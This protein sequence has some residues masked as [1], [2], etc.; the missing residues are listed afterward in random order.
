MDSLLLWS[1]QLLASHLFD[2][3]RNSSKSGFLELIT[4]S[5]TLLYIFITV[6]HIQLYLLFSNCI[7]LYLYLDLMGYDSEKVEEYET[8][9]DPAK[10][11][12]C[13]WG[14]STNA[15]IESLI[16]L[17]LQLERVDIIS[18]MQQA[19]PHLASSNT[20]CQ[21]TSE[22][23]PPA[24]LQPINNITIYEREYDGRENE[25][26]PHVVPVENITVA[27]RGV[28]NVGIEDSGSV[29]LGM[30]LNNLDNNNQVDTVTG[31]GTQQM[32][33]PVET[34]GRA[35]SLPQS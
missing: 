13:D 14:R 17:L 33:T 23:T 7:L 11:L 9:N 29:T 19:L 22:D 24:E 20:T 2:P 3:D 28:A 8:T 34:P 1:D 32:I 15:T 31:I 5:I 18:D 35:S 25:M 26:L 27:E 30:K 12:L 16:S 4:I 10:E 21:S 6:L